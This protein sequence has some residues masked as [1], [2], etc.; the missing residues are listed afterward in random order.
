MHPSLSQVFL[1]TPA[2]YQTAEAMMSEAHA[3]QV[4][5]V[6]KMAFVTFFWRI[7]CICVRLACFVSDQGREGGLCCKCF[8]LSVRLIPRPRA[9]VVAVLLTSHR[10][11]AFRIA[12]A[13]ESFSFRFSNRKTSTRSA[14]AAASA[15][16][17]TSAGK[18]RS[19]GA[20]KWIA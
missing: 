8:T 14:S 19:P 17:N 2:R 13:S 20:G 12:A 15:T 18:N 6:L 4:S 7:F 5:F 9:I 10:S 16:V 1:T 3:L 11:K